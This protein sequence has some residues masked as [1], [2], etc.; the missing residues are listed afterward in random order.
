[1]EK[2]E[3]SGKPSKSQKSVGYTFHYTTDDSGVVEKLAIVQRHDKQKGRH[4]SVPKRVRCPHCGRRFATTA[5]RDD[6]V[7]INHA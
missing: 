5:V 1:M 2:K 4:F 6:H 7:A 3:E